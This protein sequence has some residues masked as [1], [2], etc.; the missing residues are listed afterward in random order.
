MVD[1]EADSVKVS[2]IAEPPLW[3]F[4]VY[5]ITIMGHLNIA[6]YPYIYVK[7]CVASR[8]HGAAA[9]VLHVEFIISPYVRMRSFSGAQETSPDTR[10]KA[11]TFHLE[12]RSLLRK[13]SSASSTLPL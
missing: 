12:R 4:K 6:L 13:F 7:I 10:R 11:Y 9:A 1:N 2:E 5:I 3:I 8:F